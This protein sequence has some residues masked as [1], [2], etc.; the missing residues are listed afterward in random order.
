MVPDA[1]DRIRRYC[2]LPWSGGDAEVWAFH[3]ADARPS[4]LDD[5]VTTD[6]VLTAAVMHP[7]LTRSDLEWFARRAA[8]LRE[9]LAELPADLG[10]G[11]ADDSVIRSLAQL[12]RLGVEGTSLSLVTKVLHRK[13]PRLVPMLDRALLD[14]YRPLIGQRGQAAWPALVEALRHDLQ[15]SS[16]RCAL[17]DIATELLDLLPVVPTALR[18]LDIVIWMESRS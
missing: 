6:D 13:R 2:G 18:M 17:V 1:E 3:Y 4:S 15:L 10:L 14:W 8:G 7:G 9:T 11:R 5:D 16:N 12:P